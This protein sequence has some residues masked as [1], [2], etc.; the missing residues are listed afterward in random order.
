MSTLSVTGDL[1]APR[2]D[3]RGVP[4]KAQDVS[5]VL[6]NITIARASFDTTNSVMG[7]SVNV[8]SY[9]DIAVGR[10][11]LNMT[12]LSATAAGSVGNIVSSVDGMGSTDI[13]LTSDH[14]EF[15]MWD[16]GASSYADR[17]YNSTFRRGELA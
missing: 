9:T 10:W 15:R 14:W 8:A 2:D 6:N 17:L 11:D 5:H 1:A 16:C 13:P 4:A 7:G 12:T 3:L